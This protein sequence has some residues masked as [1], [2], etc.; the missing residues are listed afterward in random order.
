M[1]PGPPNYEDVQQGDTPEPT[2]V[3]KL[4]QPICIQGDNSADPKVMF[5]KVHLVGMPETWSTLKANVS[6]RVVVTLKD[7]MPAHTGHH[8]EPLVA[9]VTS[10]TAAA[11]K[12][13]FLD[14]YGTAA[15]VVR[16]FYEAL[17]DGRGET[18]AMMVVLEK[19]SK[20]PFAPDNLTRFYSHLE[21]PL[22]LL[23]I[24]QVGADTFKARY[25]YSTH[26]S[27]CDGESLVATTRREGKW[28]IES[29]KTLH[30]C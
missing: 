6:N 12:L 5:E 27:A 19:R 23:E 14:E 15:T 20:G 17:G 26:G 30:G 28:F 7:Q 8:H 18:A 24:Q 29:I 22:R 1:F 11:K 3:L 4:D 16:A 21:E 13:G 9:W 2:Y 10:V 25:H